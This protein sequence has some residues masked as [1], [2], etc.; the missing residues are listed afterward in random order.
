[1]DKLFLSILFF[2][3]TMSV[4]AQRSMNF[5]YLHT[6][7]VGEFQ[8]NLM[9]RPGG[10][11]V[12]FM[13][14][15]LKKDKKL[16]IGASFSVSMYQNED[17]TGVIMLNSN[18]EAKIEINEDDCFFTYQGIAR[19]YM[20]KQ[21]SCIRPY[22]QA[23]VGGATFFSSLTPLEDYSETLES[24]T[25]I[26]G[27]TFLTGLGGGLAIRIFDSLYFDANLIYNTSG[28][29][30]Y[31]ASPQSDPTIQYRV[32]LDSHRNTSKVNHLAMKLGVNMVF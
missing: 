29:T 12:D 10:I 8:D 22:L 14:S 6:I 21:N 3:G 24:E 30:T 2:L 28:Q 13:M 32:N 16:H 9:H 19:Y 27:T 11:A 20:T 18:E 31:R 25:R 23:Q 4:W 26:H 5:H 17:H 15:P 1:M 7:P